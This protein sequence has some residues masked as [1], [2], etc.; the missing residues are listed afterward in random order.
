MLQVN[1]GSS[2][3]GGVEIHRVLLVLRMTS[4]LH[5]IAKNRRR[6]LKVIQQGAAQI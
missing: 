3:S 1:R 4:C 5:K 2:S 6:V